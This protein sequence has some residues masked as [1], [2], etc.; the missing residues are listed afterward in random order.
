MI[1]RIVEANSKRRLQRRA[2][3]LRI[4]GCNGWT[5]SSVHKHVN[6]QFNHGNAMSIS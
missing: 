5:L 2:V 3:T 6:D 1:V 4:S